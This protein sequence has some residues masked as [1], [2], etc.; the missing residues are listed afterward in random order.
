MLEIF[1]FFED[2]GFYHSNDNSPVSTSGNSPA[3]FM[4]ST[5]E[6]IDAYRRAYELQLHQIQFA[7]KYMSDRAF[8]MHQEQNENNENYVFPKNF[9]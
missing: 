4:L 2:F 8:L 5:R 7:Q 6:E 9:S 1:D 3:N